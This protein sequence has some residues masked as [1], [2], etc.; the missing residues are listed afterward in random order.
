MGRSLSR[1]AR[2]ALAVLFAALAL[3]LVPGVAKA[4]IPEWA[5]GMEF[6]EVSFED[7]FLQD[8]DQVYMFRLYNPYT[9]EHLYT[10][11]KVEKDSL[12]AVGW[13]YEGLGWV[14]PARSATPVYRL[15]NPWV[16]GGDHHYTTSEVERDACIEAGWRDEGVGWYSAGEEGGQPLLRQYNPYA[17]TGT[18]NY[19]TAQAENDALVEAGWKEEGVG[20]YGVKPIVPDNYDD[21]ADRFEFIGY[22]SYEGLVQDFLD[23]GFSLSGSVASVDKVFEENTYF[24]PEKDL[25]R[26]A[27]YYVFAIILM[28]G[29]NHGVEYE[30][31]ELSDAEVVEL[32]QK[33]GGPTDAELAV[34]LQQI[35]FS[36]GHSVEGVERLHDNM[37]FTRG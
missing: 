1:R 33:A 30:F 35:G 10:G 17:Q 36:Y 32:I 18:H 15:Y 20:W 4:E 27:E 23:Y 31:Y 2:G 5:K 8:D 9:G 6:L 37:S 14:A 13:R 29:D 28:Y 11:D 7:D 34:Y 22:V 12:V 21:Y 25:P 24:S 19:T 16:E 26:S 3:A